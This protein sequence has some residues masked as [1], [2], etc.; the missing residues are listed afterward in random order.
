MGLGPCTEP[1]H[2]QKGKGGPKDFQPNP[3]EP[4]LFK[5]TPEEEC[6]LGHT[7]TGPMC[8]PFIVKNHPKQTWVVGWASHSRKKEENVRRP[9][10]NHNCRIK[11]K[12]ATF[13]AAL[14]WRRQANSVTLANATH[15][16]IRWMSDGTGT[17]VKVQMVN[18]CKALINLRRLYKRR[19]SP[20]R[21]DRKFENKKD[22]ERERKAI[23]FDQS[24]KCTHT[25]P[26][27]EYPMGI[28]EIFLRS[29]CCMAYN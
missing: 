8:A 3:I 22:I 17:Q 20:W 5:K 15:R 1:N 13:P 28:K 23:V 10:R 7:N 19:K 25:S 21:R 2:D 9:G 26:Q 16:K 14:M 12:K 6:L 27:T 29:N 11:C 18:K 24:Q 4:S